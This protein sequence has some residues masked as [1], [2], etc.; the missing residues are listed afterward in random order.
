MSDSSELELGA[1]RRLVVL[2]LSAAIGAISTAAIAIR[3]AAPLDSALI[4]AGRVTITCLAL[5]L[6]TSRKTLAAARLLVRARAAAGL[7][8][9]AGLCL[10]VHFAAWIAS[11]SLT[12]VVRS[13]ALVSTTPLFAG[14]LA[15]ALG[16]RAPWQL[17]LGSLVAIGGTLIMV[18]PG[19][20]G[21]GSSYLGDALALLGAVAAAIYLALGRAVPRRCDEE[22][23]LE[24]Y[25]V[26]VNAVAGLALW[27][28]AGVRGLDVQPPGVEVSCY[29]A[30]L[31]LGLVPGIFG[32]GALNWAVRRIPVH[33]VSLAVLLEPLGSALLAWPILAEV[34]T[35][36][37]AIGALGLILGVVVGIPR[38]SS[39]EAG[40]G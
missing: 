23:P 4:A 13:V 32:H 22:L 27:I 33:T 40:E 10:A 38:G 16:D 14:L 3:L 11:L 7:T 19:G 8:V 18:E 37:E 9:L 2:A 15:R 17:Y 1:Q 26:L 20:G 24:G 34:P 36:R 30:L 5:L 39:E 12:S 25:F 35:P 6:L 29:L 31:W 28:F 21:E